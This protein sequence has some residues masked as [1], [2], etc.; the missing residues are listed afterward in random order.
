MEFIGA[1]CLKKHA[2]TM[3]LGAIIHLR[4]S[5]FAVKLF[6]TQNITPAQLPKE[7]SEKSE[8]KWSGAFEV[9]LDCFTRVLFLSL[10]PC[11]C[12]MQRSVCMD[13]TQHKWS[14]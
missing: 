4:H 7:I 2:E 8:K 10:N 5:V 9:L 13:T 1:I 12:D 6:E 11:F 14:M 3:A